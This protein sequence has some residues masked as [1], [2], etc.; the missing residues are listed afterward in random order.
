MRSEVTH[1]VRS[2]PG[3]RPIVIELIGTP[4]SGKTTLSRALVKILREEGIRAATIVEAAR[5][6]VRRSILGRWVAWIAPGRVGNALLWWLFYVSGSIQA[7]A[8]AIEDPRLAEQ[9]ARSQRRRPISPRM[10]RHILFWWVQLAGRYRFLTRGTQ[11]HGALVIDDGFIHRSV[12]LH[13][14]HL[15]DPDPSAVDAY[16][17]LLPPPDLV[18]RPVAGP[19]VCERRV[20][21]RGVWTH[22]RSLGR[23]EIARS[24]RNA[25]HAVDLAVHRARMRGWNV[26]EIDNGE[27]DLELVE[28]DLRA[29]AADL[30]PPSPSGMS[31]E[32]VVR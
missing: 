9:V 8:F 2:A 3:T 29:A 7:A 12:A 18:I 25:E 32:P 14:S 17:D 16:I 6:R 20:H 10:R 11:E 15:E 31:R 28:L 4:G 5:P 23:E 24:L 13:A 21:D 22:S 26:V 30:F 27:R 19:A 1:A